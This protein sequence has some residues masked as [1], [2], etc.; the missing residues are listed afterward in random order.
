MHTAELQLIQ[1]ALSEIRAQRPVALVTE[2]LAIVGDELIER[3]EALEGHAEQPVPTDPR[4]VIVHVRPC[5]VVCVT[6]PPRN[7]RSTRRAAIPA[8]AIL[9]LSD[10]VRTY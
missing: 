4:P 7:G 9:C 1:K 5:D 2:A 8:E 10:S 6:A 3:A